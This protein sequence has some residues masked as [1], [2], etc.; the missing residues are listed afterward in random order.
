MFSIDNVKYKY[1]ENNKYLLY[2]NECNCFI[3]LNCK[4]KQIIF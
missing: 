4:M 3:C 2:S 1:C